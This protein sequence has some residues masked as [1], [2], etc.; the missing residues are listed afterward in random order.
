[1]IIS[2]P[3]FRVSDKPYFLATPLE[4]LECGRVPCAWSSPL[5]VAAMKPF[6]DADGFSAAKKKATINRRTPKICC[7]VSPLVLLT[8]R[9]EGLLHAL[10]EKTA[11]TT[12]RDEHTAIT[13]AAASSSHVAGSGTGTLATKAS[14]LPLRMP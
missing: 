7:S 11:I 6:G 8:L 10:R 14:V 13:H 1:M 12:E 2:I 3:H 5:S 4:Y 9:R